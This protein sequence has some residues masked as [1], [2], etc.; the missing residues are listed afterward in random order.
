VEAAFDQD[1]IAALGIPVKR[2]DTEQ[3]VFTVEDCFE[4][5]AEK[6]KEK[7]R[8]LYVIDSWDALSDRGELDR[9]IDK[10]TFGA[11]K[12]KQ[13]SQLFRRLVQRLK[14]S[15][16]TLMVI[17]QVRDN[18]GVTFGER[19]TRSG[20]KALDFY[21][22]QIVWL[23]QVKTLKRD[24]KGV[25]RPVGI[26]VR[27]KCKKNKVG[28]P[29]REAEFPILFGYGV[30]DAVA[31]VQWL[32]EVKRLDESGL[33]EATIKQLNSFKLLSRMNREEYRACRKTISQAVR[34]VW[35]DIEEAFAPGRLKY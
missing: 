26:Q 34:K 19:Y 2:F 20:G 17:S 30:E 3:E 13:S 1:Y 6:I 21:C 35:Q 23:S 4:D 14:K 31:S 33:D 15:N 8:G 11:G 7:E 29:F 28:P 16:I 22:S 18:I 32:E 25:S 10:S 9:D 12:A 27:A 5:L 24:L